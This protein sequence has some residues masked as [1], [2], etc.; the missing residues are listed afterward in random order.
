MSAKKEEM[1]NENK[2]LII[3]KLIE[4]GKKK[5]ILT[6]KEI[7]DALEEIDLSV[8][9]IEKVYET[10]EA[11]GIELVEDLDRELEEIQTNEE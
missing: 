7:Q 4:T 10:I 11:K 3:K 1:S 2:S 6:Y 9:Q 8:N 5:G